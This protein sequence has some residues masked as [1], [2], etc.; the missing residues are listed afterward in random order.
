MLVMI[1]A[2]AIFSLTLSHTDDAG[3]TRTGLQGL[4]VYLKP[5]FTGLTLKRFLQIR[6]VAGE[7]DGRLPLRR[8]SIP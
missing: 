6:R 8:N 2:I 4:I 7:P 3:V 1:I 5:D